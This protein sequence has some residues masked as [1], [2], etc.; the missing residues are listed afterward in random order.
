VE[1]Y[2][3]GRIACR[4][5][6]NPEDFLYPLASGLSLWDDGQA[7]RLAFLRRRLENQLFI[8]NAFD[9]LFSIVEIS[10]YFFNNFQR[11]LLESGGGS[12]HWGASFYFQP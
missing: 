9:W 5:A 12:A 1:T 4:R 7:V 2:S 10:N 11:D 6:V 8:R 3:I